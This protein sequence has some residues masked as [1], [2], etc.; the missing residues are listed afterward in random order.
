MK[1]PA[2][3]GN[4]LGQ[5]CCATSAEQRDSS[6]K[7]V[8][9]KEKNRPPTIREQRVT[10]GNE[11]AYSEYGAGVRTLTFHPGML[12]RRVPSNAPC[13]SVGLLCQLGHVRKKRVR[14]ADEQAHVS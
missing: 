12:N 11:S 8:L 2:S 3:D 5:R 1:W 7:S 4:P 14:L 9:L 13:G 10:G 6:P